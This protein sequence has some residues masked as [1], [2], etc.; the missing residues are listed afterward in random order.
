[1]TVKAEVNVDEEFAG[2]LPA[3][4]A[5]AQAALEE[6]IIHDGCRDALVVWEEMNLI[7]DGH[8]RKRICDTNEVDYRY[9]AVSL[10]DRDAAKLW[11]Y[12]NARARRNV[13]PDQ[14]SYIRGCEYNLQKKQGT[15]TDLT[16]GQNVQK[17]T[18]AEQLADNHVSRQDVQA[19]AELPKQHVI[20]KT[21]SRGLMTDS[22]S[23]APW[24]SEMNDEF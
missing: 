9:T 21:V 16:S 24:R 10:P 8:N 3:L 5:E 11:I 14:L 2:L 17:L 6:S 22:M 7:L 4:S 12:H 15:R 23:V 19:A 20:A 18:T 1:M 13:T